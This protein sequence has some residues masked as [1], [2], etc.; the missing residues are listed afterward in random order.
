[1]VQLQSHV[2][3]FIKKLITITQ[4]ICIFFYYTFK[5]LTQ[6]MFKWLYIDAIENGWRC[7]IRKCIKIK[8]IIKLEANETKGNM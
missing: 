4:Y 6:Q 5:V 2:N 3:V 8:M 1:M 7:F